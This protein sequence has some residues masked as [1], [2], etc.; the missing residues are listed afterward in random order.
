MATIQATKRNGTGKGVARE[1]RRTGRLPAILYGGPDGNVNLSLDSRAWL[2]ILEKEGANLRV[3]SQELL[4][5]GEKQEKVLMRGLQIH[6]VTGMPVHVDFMRFDPDRK[7]VVMVP[8]HVLDEAECAGLREGGILQTV[9]H[10]LEVHCRA[11]KIPHAIEVSIKGLRIG[12]SVHLRDITFPEGV[13]VFS[14]VNYTL[15]AVVAVKAEQA[16]EESQTPGPTQTP[17][18]TPS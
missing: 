14:E 1:L 7:I 16:D 15:V 6:P 13:E 18:A 2:N 11:G 17:S 5:E 9:R 10:E 12:E 3:E 8:V 4:V